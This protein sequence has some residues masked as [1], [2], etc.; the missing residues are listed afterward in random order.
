MNIIYF[1]YLNMK[2][3]E[4]IPFPD[5]GVEVLNYGKIKNNYTDNKEFLESFG[6]IMNAHNYIQM[7]ESEVINDMGIIALINSGQSK[8]KLLQDRGIANEVRLR[9]F[10]DGIYTTIVRKKDNCNNIDILLSDNFDILVNNTEFA[11]T[12]FGGVIEKI[13][14]DIDYS[15]IKIV[16]PPYVMN[17]MIFR[18]NGRMLKLFSD[19]SAKNK[20]VYTRILKSIENVAHALY[21]NENISENSRILLMIMAFNILFNIG[22]N[23]ED[24]KVAKDKIKKYFGLEDD[25][26]ITY[27][28][29]EDEEETGT[30]KKEWANSFYKLRNKIIH[31]NE[32]KKEDYLFKNKQRH[33]DIA[34][35]FFVVGIQK[36]IEHELNDVGEL[37]DDVVYEDDKFKFNGDKYSIY[38]LGK[39]IA[40][41]NDMKNREN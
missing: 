11:G 34:I 24:R 21:N 31:G 23:N 30:V 16:R 10:V 1:P 41:L 32:I 28:R 20:T 8:I 5:L 39:E 26:E 38:E 4:R 22:G 6:P 15:N 14:V 12:R 3:L 19:L 2:D 17:P 40:T 25:D 35:L 37:T 36:V 29:D 9:L 13:D 27:M 7:G 33:L 18:L